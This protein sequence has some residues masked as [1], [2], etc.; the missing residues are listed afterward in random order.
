MRAQPR[1]MMSR[2]EFN[3]HVRSENICRNVRDALERA[4][5]LIPVS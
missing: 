2:A 1:R 3:E 4:R 5:Q